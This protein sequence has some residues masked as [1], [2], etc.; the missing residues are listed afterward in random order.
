MAICDQY[1]VNVV[2]FFVVI[3]VVVA[4]LSLSKHTPHLHHSIGLSGFFSPICIFFFH[5]FRACVVCVS[6]NNGLC[7]ELRHSNKWCTR[8]SIYINATDATLPTRNENDRQ[9][10]RAR[11]WA[12]RKNAAEKK[13]HFNSNFGARNNATVTVQMP[14]KQPQQ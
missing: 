6:T 1:I 14:L 11:E 4:E 12:K 5:C 13:K 9:I 2:C 10:A 3:V 7:L 8:Q